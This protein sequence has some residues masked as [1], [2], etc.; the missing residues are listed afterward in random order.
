MRDFKKVGDRHNLL[1][2]IADPSLQQLEG[3]VKEV[4]FSVTRQQTLKDLVKEFFAHG[5]AY[6]VSL[7]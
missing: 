4:I 5:T 6:L 7:L 2:R 3:T 1:Y